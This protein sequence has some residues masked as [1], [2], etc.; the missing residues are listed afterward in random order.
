VDEQEASETQSATLSDAPAQTVKAAAPA[1]SKPSLA[2]QYEFGEDATAPVEAPQNSPSVAVANEQ[3]PAITPAPA[4]A[5]RPRNADGTFRAAEPAELTPQGPRHP[6]GLVEMALDFGIP[7]ESI[8]SFSTD[9]LSQVVRSIQRQQL[10][11]RRANSQAQTHDQANPP[12]RGSE[13]AQ[14]L[15]QPA[16]SQPAPDQGLGVDLSGFDPDVQTAFNNLLKIAKA[17]QDEIKALKAEIQQLKQFEGQRQ[18]E[19]VYDRC[20]RAFSKHEKHLGKGGRAELPPGSVHIQRRAAILNVVAADQSKAPLEAK[21]DRAVKLLYGEASEPAV[22]PAAPVDAALAGRQEQ[23]QRSG[24]AR[25]T[26]RAGA[27]EPNGKAK[28]VNSVAQQLREMG[29][30]TNATTGDA[31]ENDFIE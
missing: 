23:W 9:Q 3:A 30:A 7:D 17:P 1:S 20:D 8:S 16:A 19:T 24:L 2:D 12:S 26:N 11:E 18:T 13:A 31:D 4:A 6:S 14:S 27:A 15:S 22:V 25:P 10:E 5:E 21:I 28:A 29:S